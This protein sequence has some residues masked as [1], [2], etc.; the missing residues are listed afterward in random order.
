[1]SW[2]KAQEE[3]EEDNDDEEENEFKSGEDRIIFLIDA[4]YVAVSQL[5]VI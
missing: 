1:M 4:R 5:A 2:W 3:N